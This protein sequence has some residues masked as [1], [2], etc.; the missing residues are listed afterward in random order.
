L[1]SEGPESM[2]HIAGVENST[3]KNS[4]LIFRT[5]KQCTWKWKWW[6]KIC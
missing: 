2:G 4:K 6:I 1:E 5:G 3:C